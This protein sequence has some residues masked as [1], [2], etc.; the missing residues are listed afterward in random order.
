M[1]AYSDSPDVV[2]DF[3]AQFIKGI[4]DANPDLVSTGFKYSGPLSE[5]VLLGIAAYRTGKK[6]EWDPRNIKAIGTP[7][8]DKFFK[9]E[10]RKGWRL[11]RPK[12]ADRNYPVRKIKKKR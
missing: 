10:Y 4:Q 2:S 3:G 7:E 5:T 11:P 1:R 8:A 6:L 9:G 12:T